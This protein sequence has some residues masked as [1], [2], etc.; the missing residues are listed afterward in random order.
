MRVFPR[1]LAYPPNY[2]RATARWRPP[3]EGRAP[4]GRLATARNRL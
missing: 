3:D 2:E 1:Y 4:E